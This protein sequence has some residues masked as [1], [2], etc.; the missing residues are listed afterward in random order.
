MATQQMDAVSSF[1]HLTDHVPNWLDQLASLIQHASE[2]NAEFMADYTKVVSNL[3]PKRVKS[4]SL[5]SIHSEDDKSV[6]LSQIDPRNDA[7]LPTPP[8]A[9]EIDP[10][11]AGTKYLYAQAQKKRKPDG[12]IRS[13]ASGPQKFR[14]KN[15]VI[16]YYDSH[17]QHELDTM[18]KAVGVARN[19]L[20][21]GRNAL[22]ASRG[23]QLPTL[24][25]RHDAATLTPSLENIRSQTISR[26]GR[27]KRRSASQAAANEEEAC[28]TDVDKMLENVQN[29]CETAA[30]QFLRDGDC[31][32]ELDS[33]QTSLNAILEKA[34]RTVEV[35][36]EKANKEEEEEARAKEEADGNDTDSEMTLNNPPSME[37]L[38]AISNKKAPTSVS[39]TLDDMKTR[40]IISAPLLPTTTDAGLPTAGM[41]IEVD[42]DASEDGSLADLDISQFRLNNARH[43]RV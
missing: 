35:L 20:R 3:M 1:V 8:P 41:T 9:I 36:R 4:P 14:S 31:K 5:Q 30:H 39:L 33:A 34:V 40:A 24:S 37:H 23:F 21:K 7:T 25:R 22:N 32:M 12:S 17:L 15:Q 19:N 6:H 2:K 18:V 16:I 11:E 27:Y 38:N 42:D 43:L 10:L 13:G 29:Q 26:P 28:F